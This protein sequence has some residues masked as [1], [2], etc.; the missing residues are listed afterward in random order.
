MCCFC[1]TGASLTIANLRVIMTYVEPYFWTQTNL[2]NLKA[3]QRE[4]PERSKVLGNQV[5]YTEK[6]QMRKP[7]WFKMFRIARITLVVVSNTNIMKTFKCSPN[8]MV[9]K[10]CLR[11]IA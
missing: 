4:E 1:G 9:T 8:F 7:L 2:E 11:I 10:V 6:Y 3:R 5:Y